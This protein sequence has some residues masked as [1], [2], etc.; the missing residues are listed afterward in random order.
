MK[1]LFTIM[2]LFS[3]SYADSYEADLTAEEAYEMQKEG[4]AII[5]DVRTTLEFLYTGHGEGF[6]NIPSHFWTYDPK[7]IETR[8][9]SAEYEIQNSKVK[10]HPSSMK[11][12]NAKEV[13]NKNFVSEVMKAMKIRGADSVIL[14]CRSGPRSKFAANMLS[15]E[16]ITAYNL[17]DGFIFGWKEEKMPWGGE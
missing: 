7:S 16:G 8:V 17:E 1:L 13:I 5:V 6:I 2:M 10:D 14:V 4:K 15:K 11:L 9:K 12:Y 3:L